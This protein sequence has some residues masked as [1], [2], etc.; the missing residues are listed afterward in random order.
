MTYRFIQELSTIEW[1]HQNL[2]FLD[3]VS[4]DNRGM[5]RKHGYAIKSRELALRG[6]F[7]RLP[8]TSLLALI[9]ANGLIDFF[10]TEGTFDRVKFFTCCRKFAY[11]TR[12]NI[13]QYPGHNSVRIDGAIIHCDP[14]IVHFLRSIGVMPI[15][16]PACC[17]FFS[18]VAWVNQGGR[19]SL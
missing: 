17:P 18:S 13:R 10:D 2:V 5:I 15:F 3:E 12:G 16:L 6:S 11:S 9:G 19:L 4:F 14:E 7:R 8:R 1:G